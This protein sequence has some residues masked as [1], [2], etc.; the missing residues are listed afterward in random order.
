MILI[1]ADDLGYS[2]L[3]CYGSEIQTPNLDKM[4]EN[5]I[6]FNRFYNQARCC[7][8]RAALLTGL[9]AH[10]AGMGGMVSHIGEKREDGPYQ[11]Y[12][13]RDVVTIAEALQET[14]YHSYI[15]GKWH[16]GEDQENWPLQ[17]G[18]ER[19]FGLISGASSYFELIKNQPRHRQMALDDKSWE[20]P[21]EGFYM[22][23]A[24][25]DYAIQW[26]DEHQ[27]KY[28]SPFFL[29]VAY[30]APHWPLHALPEDIEK[31]AGKFTAGWD[32]LRVR[33]FQRLRDIGLIDE[34]TQLSIR[35]DEI[36]AWESVKNQEEWARKMEVYA[37]MIDRMDQDIGRIMNN[38]KEKKQFD[39]TLILFLSDNGAS[40]ENIEGRK[41]NNP[42]VPIGLQG[43]YTAYQ[44]PWA[45]LSNTPFRYFKKRVHEGGITSPFIA[46]WPA[47]IH[48]KGEILSQTGHII[49]LMPTFLEIAGVE[50]PEQFT[51]HEINILDGVSL[52]PALTKA[53][54]VSR[55][56]LY[57]E[58][59][60]NR[61]LRQGK[62]KLVALKG[63]EWQLYNLQ[64]DGSETTDLS[65]IY[66]D[67]VEILKN[68]YEEWA[69][70]VGVY[71]KH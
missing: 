46:H 48:N 57:W 59:E 21:A 61:A 7:P 65:H 70:K 66:P 42:S 26:I 34:N 63:K 60:G 10:N 44:T 1:L 4:A 37:A 50:L 55:D 12:L 49:D 53:N 22:T 64:R 35:P 23:D 24:I 51:G 17:R 6:R 29:Y 15:S 31:Y 33:R 56:A 54:V 45:H 27:Q 39:N 32:S 28:D 69:R 43:S 52:A 25:T 20:P 13:S 5:G 18:F 16:V 2:D 47:G 30:T 9:Y 67:T 36:P 40:D 3:G 11:G 38:L 8:S 14:G 58:H 62:W 19:Y 41:L 68:K 71:E